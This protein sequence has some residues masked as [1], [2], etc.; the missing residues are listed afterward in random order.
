MIS[1]TTRS[2]YGIAALLELA[3]R[4]AGELTQAKAIAARRHIPM[5][6]LEQILGVVSRAGLVKSVRGTHGGYTL[7]RPAG[8]ISVLELLTAL[9]ARAGEHGAH[10]TSPGVLAALVHEAELAVARVFNL[11]LQ[12]LAERERVEDGAMFYI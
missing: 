1:L 9:E 7:A 5:K 8:R 11:S 10:Q 6:Y 3:G 12:E 4:P 2:Q